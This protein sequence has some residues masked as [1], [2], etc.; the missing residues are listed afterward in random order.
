MSDWLT[1]LRGLFEYASELPTSIAI[2]ESLYFAPYLTVAHVVVMS[3]VAGLVLMM[4]LR[5]AGL[6]NRS[7]PPDV[8]QKRLFPWQMLGFIFVT[9]TGG[10][11]FY[12]KPL[13]YYGKGYFWLKM[14]LIVLAGLN[15]GLI[16]W[17]TN[18]SG[19]RGWDSGLAKFAGLASIVLWAA[20]TVTGRLVAY[21]WW[22]T[23]YFLEF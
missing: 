12:S 9:I 18:R 10:L 7:T 6:G 4:D 23:E 21:E 3:I 14:G 17:V 22:T 19:G 13:T 11:L 15:A 1:P 2:R 5:L 20:I 16:H 8:I